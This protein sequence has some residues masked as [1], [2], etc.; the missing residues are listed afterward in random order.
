M[1]NARKTWFITG[2]SSGFG[3]AFAAHALERGYNV[4]ATAR[5]VAKLRD[6][7]MQAPERVL[8]VE[9]DVDRSGAAEMALKAAITRFGRIDVVINNAGYGSSARS[10]RR[11]RVSCAP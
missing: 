6:L 5:N 8:D 1:S 2:A 4:V 9:F 11:Q 10:K 7:T 3:R